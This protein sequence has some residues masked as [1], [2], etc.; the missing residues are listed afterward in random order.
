[1]R[2]VVTSRAASVVSIVK[3]QRSGPL[4]M[5][6]GTGCCDSTAPF[7]FENHLVEPEAELVGEVNGVPVY[8]PGWL[9]RSYRPDEE[10][11]IE[12]VE[13]PSG[14]SFSVESEMGLRFVLLHPKQGVV[15]SVCGLDATGAG[16]VDAP[17]VGWGVD[18][19]RQEKLVR[20]QGEAKELP[21]DG[22]QADFSPAG[23]EPER[24]APHPPRTPPLPSLRLP[25]DLAE[26]FSNLQGK[27]SSS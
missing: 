8:A 7:L 3:K 26:R 10:L 2:V 5:T 21:L 23:D 18:A 1:M 4:T 6:I 22:L 14:E 19:P 13:D 12:V 24:E 27:S 20:D 9:A 17:G 15:S 11:V 16:G 25:P